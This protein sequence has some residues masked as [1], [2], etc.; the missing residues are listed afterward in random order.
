MRRGVA[1][2]MRQWMPAGLWE[3]PADRPLVALTF[4][5]APHREVTAQILDTL[6]R[7][8]VPA[9]FFVIGGRAER[10]PELVRRMQAEGHDVGN[11]TWSHRPLAYGLGHSP[12][13]ELARTEALLTELAPGSPRIFRPP[14]GYIGP[15]GAAVL[16][17]T[18]LLPV[19]WS[20]IPADWDPLPGKIVERRVLTAIHPGAVVVLHCGQSWHR[21][22]AEALE[23]MVRGVR[24]RGLELVTVRRMLAEMGRA[25][26]LR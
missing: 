18:E 14:F 7:L 21:G 13:E 4:D 16:R 9:T 10:N 5:D 2:C 20:V 12:Y 25:V 24:E 1:Q 17:R 6:A 23:G 15:G 3:G 26:E 8:Q 19:Y 22:T 11:H